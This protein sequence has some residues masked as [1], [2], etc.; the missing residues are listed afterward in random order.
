MQASLNLAI[1]N[2]KRYKPLVEDGLAQGKIDELVAKSKQLQAVDA[3]DAG[4]NKLNLMLS[5]LEI[6]ATI[7]GKIGQNLID[8]GNLAKC[9]FNS[10]YKNCWFKKLYVILIQVLKKY[11]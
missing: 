8:V 11:L 6:K 5:I 4:I 9:N 3:S 7:D 2:V 10:S 1:S